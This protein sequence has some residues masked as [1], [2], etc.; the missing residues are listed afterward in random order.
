MRMARSIKPKLSIY[1]ALLLSAVLVLS[2]S[3]TH[4][5]GSKYVPAYNELVKMLNDRLTAM[6]D[7]H[8]LDPKAPGDS[9]TQEELKDMRERV[10]G[11]LSA[12]FCLPPEEWNLDLGDHGAAFP[13]GLRYDGDNQL[14]EPSLM[15]GIG[16]NGYFTMVPADLSEDGELHHGASFSDIPLLW[17]H[18]EELHTAISRM[19]WLRPYFSGGE[20]TAL[21]ENNVSSGSVR[22]E[23]TWQAATAAADGAYVEGG[24]SVDV[25][26]ECYN[27]GYSQDEKYTAVKHLQY[28]YYRMAGIATELGV[29]AHFFCWPT[30]VPPQWA[31]P[32]AVY[33]DFGTGLEA[34]R[35][36]EWSVTGPS[37]PGV[38]IS[39]ALGQG[40]IAAPWCDE[41]TK[42]QVEKNRGFWV[43]IMDR[44]KAV[45]LDFSDLYDGELTEPEED[46]AN[47][48]GVAMVGCECSECRSPVE[49]LQSDAGTA[50]G[51]IRLGR[52][53]GL[54]HGVRIMADIYERHL[55]G[56]FQQAFNLDTRV[57]RRARGSAW[58]LVLLMRPCGAEVLFAFKGTDVA[59]P[60]NVSA[61]Y[62][63]HRIGDVL[64]LCFDEGQRRVVHRFGV[65]STL[66]W[67]RVIDRQIDATVERD[68]KTWP[69]MS[70][71]KD[72]EYRVE[73]V[74]TDLTEA[75]VTYAGERVAS[76]DYRTRG[77]TSLQTVELSSGG[78]FRD[79]GTEGSIYREYEPDGTLIQETR[80]V[81]IEG[82]DPANGEVEIWRGVSTNGV[83]T[84]LR[85][86]I[87]RREWDS[88]NA[89]ERV[90]T[91]SVYL[92]DTPDAQ[93]NV[94]VTTVA[95]YTWG[96]P[97]IARVQG[98][99]TTATAT[100]TWSHHSNPN[101]S[102]NFKKIEY[103]QFPDGSW[104]R[105]DAYDAEGRVKVICRP[106]EDGGPIGPAGSR[107][108]FYTYAGDPLLGTLN[109]PTNNDAVVTHDTRPRLEVVEL[110]GEEISR[111]YHAYPPGQHITKRCVQREAAYDA[112]EN[113]TT[114]ASLYDDGRP[115]Q[116][117]HEDG[118]LSLYSYKYNKTTKQMT[119][120]KSTGSGVGSSVTNGIRTITILDA[121]SRLLSSKK[122][123]IASGI[124]F[125]QFTY[126]R[127]G[128]GR[129]TRTTD[130]LN[131]R[132]RATTHG[133]CGPDVEVDEDGIETSYA[134]D[135]LGR[136]TARQRL[137][138]TEEY[139]YDVLGNV[140]RTCRSAAGEEDAIATATYDG[141]GRVLTATDEFGNTTAY[142]YVT[143]TVEGLTTITTYP[144][145][146]THVEQMYRDGRL[147]RIGGT[148]TVPVFYNYIAHPLGEC[149]T[150]YQGTNG[151]A[152]WVRTWWNM[153]GNTKE[154][155]YPEGYSQVLTYDD[156][157]RLAGT[158]DAH[159]RVLTAY[160][161]LG[162]PFRQAID[163]NANGAIDL[164]GPDRITETR[165]AYRVVDGVSV[166]ET[167]TR[168]YGEAGS[169]AFTVTGIARR[170]VDGRQS[171]SVSFGRTNHTLIAWDRETGR[172]SE[173]LTRPDGTQI[174]STYHQGTLISE[175]TRDSEG[176]LVSM[177]ARTHNALW[178]PNVVQDIA[179]DGKN[180]FRW[181]QYDVGGRPTNETVVVGGLT[182]TRAYA[183]DAMGRGILTVMPDG[184]RV[185]TEYD[186]RGN[187]VRRSGARMWPVGY[188]YDERGR[189][190]AL[191]TYRD[192][193]DGPAD[194]TSWVYDP[195]RGWLTEKRYADGSSVQYTYHMNGALQRR[196]WARG[197][198]T[199]YSYDDA[200]SLRLI[201]Y[202]DGTPSVRYTRDRLG[203][204]VT[205]ADAIG[206]HT[207]TYTVDGQLLSSSLPQCSDLVLLYGY[208]AIGR[209]AG[210][211]LRDATAGTPYHAIAYSYDP[212]GRLHV[213]SNDVMHALYTYAADGFS[214][215]DTTIASG[216][217]VIVQTAK[218]HD[219]LGRVFSITNEV[220]GQLVSSSAY[221]YNVADQRTE[222][223]LGDGSQW[224]YA[225]DELGQVVSGRKYFDD[226]VMDGAAQF[227][228]RYDT[229]GNRTSAR[230]GVGDGAAAW[231]YTAND[232][233]QYTGVI[234]PG[235]AFVGG[236]TDLDADVSVQSA[237][238]PAVP[239]NRHGASFWHAMSVDNS[240]GPVVTSNVVC[241]IKTDGTN[242]LVRTE[243]HTTLIPPHEVAPTYDADGNLL[244]DGL[245][246]YT[247]NGEN[248]L[249]AAESLAGVPDEAKVRVVNVYDYIGRRVR[250]TVSKDY[251]GGT[252]AITNVTTYVWDGFN[253]IAEMCDAGY[254]NWHT[255]GLDLSG[256][257]Q[258][259]GGVGG[260]LAMTRDTGT[261]TN[262]YIYCFDGNGNVVNL[263]DASDGSIAATYEYDPFGTLI[264]STGTI[265]SDNPVRW[266]TKHTDDETDLV[267]YP[268]RPYAP[269]LGRWLSRDGIGENGGVN[270]YGFVQNNPV[271]YIDPRGLALYAFD[272]TGTRYDT[273]THISIL[274]RSYQGTKKFYLEGVG[275]RWYSKSFGGAFGLGGQGRVSR[276]YKRLAETYEED[277]TIDIIGFSRGAALARD[278]ANEI[279]K[280]GIV[281][282]DGTVIECNPKIRF[283]GLFDT[284]GSF[285]WPGNDIN[286]GVTM[287][288]PPNVERAAQAVAAHERRGEFPLTPLNQ[289]QGG[290]V[291]SRQVFRGDHSDIGGGHLENQNILA[292][293][294]L[295]YIWRQGRAAGVPFSSITVEEGK[296]FE[297]Y[298]SVRGERRLWPYVID[299]TPHDLTDKLLYTDAGPRGNLPT[300]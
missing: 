18:F 28:A 240:T 218:R 186:A 128:F 248:R 104:I 133:C 157:G 241:A 277:S 85:K 148:A 96:H 286:M 106:F 263:V 207:N 289:A 291:F 89:A 178:L 46:D 158:S 254:T 170:S 103:V 118:T 33:D 236:E 27:Y 259:A 101:D 139:T 273:W 121:E 196:T 120:T 223:T 274:H 55:N 295:L 98:H 31:E 161:D 81:P 205:A 214:M 131:G 69:G 193:L 180:R 34:H 147:K 134:Y 41:P 293:Q 261:E 227:T 296:N 160:D 262:T 211:E 190:S 222:Q 203:R 127:D 87:T 276:M 172:R 12:Y 221:A 35:W 265:A 283:V 185:E 204:V 244:T 111:T 3:F 206:I 130:E 243:M 21:G 65:F 145:G 32:V 44:H 151:A 256:S 280:K 300:P 110:L 135:L 132:Y 14:V 108:T 140:I 210:T 208:D 165:T 113:L 282:G 255:Y 63:L 45:M 107:A 275:S 126:E 70:Y 56:D 105:Y 79:G 68:K 191:R 78:A 47:D 252:Y 7:Q 278:F 82:D 86:D 37:E 238:G 49:A 38:I 93:T 144:D 54:R 183:Y 268:K 25:A 287:D 176:A 115:W 152:Q 279:Y 266:S 125:S 213:V 156:C 225:Y 201:G 270:L 153:L 271:L 167:A 285:G 67:V 95:S 260:A 228:Y 150:E 246:S 226:G 71:Y 20:W 159:I 42:T 200:G 164:G 233:N 102:D 43:P 253:I 230:Q 26:P 288:L 80:I 50:M 187:V 215:Y 216:A 138:V 169:E 284:V 1:G 258:G 269:T 76:V 143:N 257:L 52:S 124:T 137:G 117:D 219:G 129:V 119:V 122:E 232:V 109:F 237:T 61:S 73:R 224:R 199:D 13:F 249:V 290:Q 141:R 267:M 30:E 72:A 173:T 264:R 234:T 83:L 154:T 250:K 57:V 114:I 195:V 181:Y 197:V 149:M 8:T 163:M 177:T 11:L 64:E 182:Q 5:S 62:K 58:D 123:D 242:S 112:P 29:E 297:M 155:E 272:G 15:E 281:K 90:I 239:A 251:S 299:N 59:D 162:R 247:W 198:H 16:R 175:E 99:G 184:A 217:G 245:F 202:S 142:A 39:E 17:V 10:R 166:H 2:P 100:T 53:S 97:I 136:K 88:T 174:E 36:N 84:V 9:V 91:T 292:L 23:A 24:D 77:G 212:A 60:V 40:A 294:P 209:P 19:R 168:E 4:A 192:G 66:D 48:N 116:I 6:G 235:T 75:T 22:D 229:I 179:P 189:L 298:L 94:A 51:R 74:V 220:G 171:W 92:P 194:E 188:A 231:A 146:S